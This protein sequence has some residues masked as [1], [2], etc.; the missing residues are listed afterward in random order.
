[1][2]EPLNN[3]IID[4]IDIDDDTFS[5]MDRVAGLP[6]TGIPDNFL[7][8]TISIFVAIFFSS[9]YFGWGGKPDMI[10]ITF[11]LLLTLP[12]SIATVYNY[13]ATSARYRKCSGKTRVM[14]EIG[15]LMG[16]LAIPLGTIIVFL[17]ITAL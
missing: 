12:L 7:L 15:V 9:G 10:S 8:G 1:M 14:R 6:D 4:A 3:K 16:L 2:E 5:E 17:T 13:T 11:A